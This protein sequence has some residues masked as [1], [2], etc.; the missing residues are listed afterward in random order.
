MEGEVAMAGRAGL[1]KIATPMSAPA[2]RSVQRAEGDEG[3]HQSRVVLR[4]LWQEAVQK[5]A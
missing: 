1:R 2:F 3:G 5:I 4:H